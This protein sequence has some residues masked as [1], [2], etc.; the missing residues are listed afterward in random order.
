MKWFW[1]ISLATVFKWEYVSWAYHDA[2]CR[3]ARFVTQSS[4]IQWLRNFH[5]FNSSSRGIR[6]KKLLVDVF[7][8]WQ[9]TKKWAQTQL[10]AKTTTTNRCWCKWM[11][12]HSFIVGLWVSNPQHCT[13]RAMRPE[14]NKAIA[15]DLYSRYLAIMAWPLSTQDK[16]N[17]QL[18]SSW[19]C[20]SR[21][22]QFV[23]RHLSMCF[24]LP[25]W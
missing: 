24:F 3:N 25:I 12:I 23:L 10:S 16:Q 6:I 1:L 5:K 19:L 13:Q 2:L 14:V 18:E 17:C 11:C 9:Q 21:I 8:E 20:L 22:Y 7:S 4:W 15:R